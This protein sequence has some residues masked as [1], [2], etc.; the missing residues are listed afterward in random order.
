[1]GAKRK[2]WKAQLATQLRVAAAH[3]DVESAKDALTGLRVLEEGCLVP[4]KGGASALHYASSNA[5][6]KVTRLLLEARADANTRDRHN[7]PPLDAVA[8]YQLHCSCPSKRGRYKAVFDL[9]E[10]HGGRRSADGERPDQ[11]HFQRYMDQ[12][13][14]RAWSR[15]ASPRSPVDVVESSD[16]EHIAKDVATKTTPD[17]VK[18]RQPP[19][20]EASDSEETKASSSRPMVGDLLALKDRGTSSDS[21]VSQCTGSSSD[22]G[23][24]KASSSQPPRS[25][26]LRVRRSWQHAANTDGGRTGFIPVSLTSSEDESSRRST[27]PRERRRRGRRRNPVV[28]READSCRGEK[29]DLSDAPPPP[30]V[31]LATALGVG[32]ETGISGGQR[33]GKKPL[34]ER[35]TAGFPQPAHRAA[36]GS[37]S[38]G[39]ARCSPFDARDEPRGQASSSRSLPAD[40]EGDPARSRSDRA[41]SG[42]FATISQVSEAQPHEEP[43]Q[44]SRFAWREMTARMEAWR[45]WER[46]KRAETATPQNCSC[47][48]SSR[49]TADA[50]EHQSSK[51]SS[52]RPVAEKIEP[53]RPHIVEVKVEVTEEVESAKARAVPKPHPSRSKAMQQSRPAQPKKRPQPK[54]SAATACSRDGRLRPPPR[55]GSEHRRITVTKA[56]SVVAASVDVSSASGGEDAELT[57]VAFGGNQQEPDEAMLQL[58]RSL[59]RLRLDLDATSEVK[60]EDSANVKEEK[61]EPPEAPPLT[62]VG[63]SVP[64]TQAAPV[65][66]PLPRRLTPAQVQIIHHGTKGVGSYDPAQSRKALHRYRHLL[67]NLE[68]RHLRQTHDVVSSRFLHGP[69]AGECVED[70]TRLLLGGYDVRKVT[71]LVVARCV[72]YN[73]VIFGNRRLKALKAYADNVSWPVEVP[74]ILHDFDNPHGQVPLSLFCKFLQSASTTNDG[75][76]AD[77]RREYTWRG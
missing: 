2:S 75:S 43:S 13:R 9:L 47:P 19:D 46:A 42:T 6:I 55:A 77:F 25:K 37:H 4:D 64:P 56:P 36:E 18:G 10:A 11:A 39:G 15:G 5:S 73:W 44:R 40:L 27:Q 34:I 22:S 41:T 16:D 24:T 50:Q 49:C 76:F 30:G 38:L 8:Y 65:E 67:R 23:A 51:S 14:R 33:S 45:A 48:S 31:I 17:D 71:P 28:L 59:L 62:R 74:C 1:M 61:V 63:P 3:D 32:V 72:G 68:V 52:A 54:G 69:H 70:L 20:R 53:S 26:K 7:A 58:L 66:P 29:R 12:A 35:S 60:K 21:E 57:G